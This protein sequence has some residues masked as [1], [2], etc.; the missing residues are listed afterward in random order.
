MSPIKSD[1]GDQV[2]KIY[3]RNYGSKAR[4]LR[5]KKDI[6]HRQYSFIGKPEKK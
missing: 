4:E 3:S 1:H 6:V 5:N 2:S